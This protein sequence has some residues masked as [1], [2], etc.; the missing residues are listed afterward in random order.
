M[1]EAGAAA[2]AVPPEAVDLLRLLAYAVLEP[3]PPAILVAVDLRV[4]VTVSESVDADVVIVSDLCPGQARLRRHG[5][6]QRTL[7]GLR[8]VVSAIEVVDALLTER[9]LPVPPI[10]V[11]I[12]SGLHRGGVGFGLGSSGAVTVAAVTAVAAYCGV[13]LSPEARYRLA[14]LA[15]AR[16]DPGPSGG[17]L[18]ASVWGGWIAYQAPDRVAVLDLARRRVSRRRCARHGWDSGCAGCRRRADW[19]CGWAGPDNRPAPRR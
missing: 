19:R 4:S 11:S 6:E 8:H 9:G 2:A 14:M 15:T 7:D 16:H 17:D 10:H 13:T 5:G 12:T 18:A 1:R 3:G